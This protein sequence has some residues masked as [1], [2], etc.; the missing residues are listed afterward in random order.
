MSTGFHGRQSLSGRRTTNASHVTGP[1]IDR[2]DVA[3]RQLRDT[4]AGEYRVHPSVVA[5]LKAETL[6]WMTAFRWGPLHRVR[7]YRVP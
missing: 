2:R 1:R 3:L 7:V 6:A 4:V 5:G